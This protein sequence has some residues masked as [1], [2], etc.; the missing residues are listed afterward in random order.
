MAVILIIMA[1]GIAALLAASATM[2]SGK[3]DATIFGE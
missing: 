1:V 3:A 2:V